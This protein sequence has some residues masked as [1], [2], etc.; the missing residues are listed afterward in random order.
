MKQLR[1]RVN[2]EWYT[3]EVGD[4]YQSPVE[5]VVDGETYL[6]ELDTAVE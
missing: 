1:V 6:V 4:V 2:G 3:V 5:V